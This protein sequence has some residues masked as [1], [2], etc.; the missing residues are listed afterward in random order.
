MLIARLMLGS[1]RK[2]MTRRATI[3][4]GMANYR[5]S[6]VVQDGHIGSPPKQLF[7]YHEASSW[8][9]L[10]GVFLVGSSS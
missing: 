4:Y 5:M 7:D 3:A 6:T 1:F 2:N 9:D 10:W 8:T